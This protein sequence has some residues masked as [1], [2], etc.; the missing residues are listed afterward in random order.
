MKDYRRMIDRLAVSGPRSGPHGSRNIVESGIPDFRSAGGLWSKYDPMEY[1][2]HPIIQVKSQESWQM[3]WE[4]DS[5][6]AE[7]SRTRRT[8]PRRLERRG[9][10]KEVITQKWTACIRGRGADR[11]SSFMGT[12]GPCAVKSAVAGFMREAVRFD[13]LPPACSCGGPL[14]PELVFFG[15]SSPPMPLNM[16]WKPHG[17][18]IS[19]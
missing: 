14:R 17:C 13:T 11:L 3:L 6:S 5:C 7:R 19:S 12:T 16:R 2:S 1:A 10:I 15:N 8:W 18:V 4:I 9:I